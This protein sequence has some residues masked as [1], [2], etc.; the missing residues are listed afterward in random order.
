MLEQRNQLESRTEHRE[1][2]ARDIP[3]NPDEDLKAYY[4]FKLF[5]RMYFSICAEGS[6]APADA[7]SPSVLYS[8]IWKQ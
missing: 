1:I 6:S 3:P 5:T 8:P 7:T 4:G 2:A